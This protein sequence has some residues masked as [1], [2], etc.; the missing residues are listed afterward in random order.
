LYLSWRD[1]S[2]VHNDHVLTIH[3]SE[4]FFFIPT[5]LVLFPTHILIDV[6]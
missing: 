6:S 1:L 4:R 2:F 5:L 3:T